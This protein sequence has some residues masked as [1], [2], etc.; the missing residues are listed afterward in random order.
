[1]M[2]IGPIEYYLLQT[3]IGCDR[4][5]FNLSDKSSFYIK[6]V[7]SI[8]GM[9]LFFVYLIIN[10]DEL[11]TKYNNYLLMIYFIYHYSIRLITSFVQNYI[12]NHKGD[13]KPYKKISEYL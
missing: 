10:L 5:F 12:A 4:M 13:E 3:K 8:L 11:S 6:N 1:M 7:I 2:D 9:L